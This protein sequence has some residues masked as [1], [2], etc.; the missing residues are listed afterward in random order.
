MLS[1]RFGS[2]NEW[3]VSGSVFDRLFDAAIGYELMPG[4]LE[5]WRY[6]VDANGGMDVNKEKP[7]DAGRFKAALLESAQRELNSVER[8]QD[9]WTY[10]TSLEKLVKLLAKD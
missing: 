6:V 2:E 1:V 7:Q 4:D 10:T 3:W 9:N 5:D 8:T